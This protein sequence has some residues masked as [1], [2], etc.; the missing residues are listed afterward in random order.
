MENIH[1][2]RALS[3]DKAPPMKERLE[4]P[5]PESDNGISPGILRVLHRQ[6]GHIEIWQQIGL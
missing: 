4:F 6:V 5:I 1:N 2:Y 3:E